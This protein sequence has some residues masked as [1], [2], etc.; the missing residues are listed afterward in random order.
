M[1]VA[2]LPCPRVAP[3]RGSGVLGVDRAARATA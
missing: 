2:T 3:G 1:P